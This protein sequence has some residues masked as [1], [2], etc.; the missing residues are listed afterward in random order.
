MGL[1]MYLNGEK[2]LWTNWKEPEKNVMEDGFKLTTKTLELGYWRK[3]PDLHGFIV[4][5]FAEGIDECQNIHL[6]KEDLEKILSAVN[7]ENLPHTEGFFF[8][9]SS[10][11]DRQPTIVILEKAIKWLEIK[12]E[13]VSRSVIYRASW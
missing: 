13:G 9:E 11:E 7:G 3:H 5:T 12:E 8:G 4:N 10:P 1:N 2:F 6:D